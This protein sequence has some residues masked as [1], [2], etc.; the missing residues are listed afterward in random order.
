MSNANSMGSKM[1]S[2]PILHPMI[3][4]DSEPKMKNTIGPSFWHKVKTFLFTPNKFIADLTNQNR[5]YRD[6]DDC[7]VGVMCADDED[8]SA[9]S[10]SSVYGR[11]P[12]WCTL[13]G[14]T[15]E[16][17]KPGQ[18]AKAVLDLDMRSMYFHLAVWHEVERPNCDWMIAPYLRE[19]QDDSWFRGVLM[20]EESA[21]EEVKAW[22]DTYIERVGNIDVP[23][24]LPELVKG[25]QISGIPIV[26]NGHA[27]I[28]RNIQLP[29]KD[30]FEEWCW[31]TKNCSGK[32]MFFDRYF[33]IDDHTEALTFELSR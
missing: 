26:A 12:D 18:T 30:L 22:F 20:V 19:N 11:T 32:F 8:R 2:L 5:R 27:G 7:E 17:I 33:L 28:R 1:K 24:A 3:F 6:D 10:P 16:Q 31:L 23:R 4:E 13:F 21:Y 15:I 29:D 25:K 14:E 9:V